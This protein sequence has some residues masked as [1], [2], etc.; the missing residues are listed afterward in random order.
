MIDT[1]SYHLY[2]VKTMTTAIKAKFKNGVLEPLT[3]VNLLEGE[4]VTVRIEISDVDDKAWLDAAA[5][6][7]NQLSERESLI[8]ILILLCQWAKTQVFRTDLPLESHHCATDGIRQC[9]ARQECSS[10]SESY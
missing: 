2:H 8:R 1:K 9:C 7:E 6:I 5:S 10:P 3:K 4:E